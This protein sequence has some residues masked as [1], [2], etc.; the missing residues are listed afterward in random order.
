VRTPIEEGRKV[1]QVWIEATTIGDLVD[2]E[3]ARRPG[4][5][6]LVFPDVRVTYAELSRRSDELARSL[7][8]LGVAP[9]DKVGI[10]MPN[11]LDFA[12][13]LFGA[14]KLGAV[15]VPI[16][17]R[18]R[19]HELGHV[20]EHADLRVLLTVAG[21]AGSVDYP[22]LIAQVFVDLATADPRALALSGA[23]L[24]RQ[25]VD[26]GASGLPGFL[27]RASFEDAAAGVDA[28]EVRALQQRVRLRDIALLMYTSGTTA[29]PKG[30]LL[31]HEAL[32]RHGRNVALTC[33][34][35]TADDRFW[36]PLPLFHIGGI[37]PMLGTLSVGA[38]YYHAGHFDPTQAL[39][40]LEQE[41]ITVAYPAFE[42]IWLGVLNHPRF[43]H[44]DLSALRLIQN[45]A[46]P[47]RLAQMQRLLPGAIEVSSFGSTESSSNLTLTRPDDDE[48]VRLNTLGHAVP[49]VE[50]RIVDHVTGEDCEVDEVGEL[51]FRGYSLFEGYYKAPELTAEA[52]DGD[53]WF[54]SGDLAS[55]DAAGR[56]VYA[57]RMKDMLKVGG[58]NVSAVEVESFLAA[59]PAIDIVNVVG[60]P[61]ARY[62]D[63]PAAFVQLKP[64]ARLD[65][66][67]LIDFCVGRIA[68]YKIPRYVR[69]VDEWPMSGTKIQK[70]VLRE[71][72][73]AELAERGIAEA[74]K[75][76]K[77]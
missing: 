66:R 35:L 52:I 56:L 39:D 32:V 19:T 30:C 69:I 26:L 27:D 48:D 61:D 5:E 63:V 12:V 50:L 31:T 53:G 33:F 18:F 59:H 60:A 38:C 72:I 43:P 46:V 42:T 9:Q 77:G 64:G 58:E 7:R 62:A 70:F 45:I 37:V 68:T 51:L 41:R 76:Q 11:C 49:G 10:L 22:G 2:R 28:A 57:G 13:A 17:G 67:E 74:P 3:A 34:W 54:H 21:P 20:I 23:P 25:V 14:A 24:L 71:R 55:M 6:A 75:L 4:K 44:A 15:V 8:G 47:E 29:K 1:E 40:T 36:D 65:E 73:A 16:N